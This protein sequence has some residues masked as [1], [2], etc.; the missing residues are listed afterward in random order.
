MIVQWKEQEKVA[1]A[2]RINNPSALD[3]Y[4]VQLN[5]GARPQLGTATWIASGITIE[6]VQIALAMD[7][8]QIDRHPTE[9]Q[10]LKIG[11]YQIRLQH[12]IDEFIVGAQRYLGDDYDEDNNI[13]DMDV[14]FTSN[15]PDSTDDES[16]G[17]AEPEGTPRML[18]QP[19]CILILLPPN[20]GIDR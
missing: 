10:T 14:D 9:T 19:Q 4:N 6:E 15:L 17:D 5:K 12:S 20:L 18:F 2:S 16:E 11:H 8:H 1:Q 3:V 7:I 13:Q